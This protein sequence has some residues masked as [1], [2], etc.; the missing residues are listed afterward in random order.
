MALML[1]LPASGCFIF[2][3]SG[4]G[5]EGTGGQAD[6]GDAA[7]GADETG[8]PEPEPEPFEHRIFVAQHLEYDN[9]GPGGET[10]YNIHEACDNTDVADDT[11]A[12]SNAMMMDG[13]QVRYGFDHE[14]EPGAAL[15]A[16]PDSWAE[17]Y[18]IEPFTEGFATPSDEE[19]ADFF[20]L[21]MYSGH[22]GPGEFATNFDAEAPGENTC[23]VEHGW[24]VRLGLYCGQRAKVAAY[25]A[26]CVAG[27]DEGL[28]P[29]PPSA[30]DAGFWQPWDPVCWAPFD[31]TILQSLLNQTL[32]FVD[33]PIVSVDQGEVWYSHTKI[34]QAP[35]VG[36]IGTHAL[37]E[38]SGQ[39]NQPAAITRGSSEHDMSGHLYLS[40]I[41]SGIN[42]E[43]IL[44]EDAVYTGII[45]LSWEG[46]S[47]I[48][49]AEGEE[50][51]YAAQ[52]PETNPVCIP[53]HFDVCDPEVDS[54]NPPGVP[55]LDCPPGA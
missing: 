42:L 1:G 23:Y 5:E 37:D 4:D 32:A 45:W 27:F 46:H 21:A 51:I 24:D 12:M 31:C 39:A 30:E 52:A 11:I 22:G 10:I 33:S 2:E 34:V 38:Q 54:P 40:D 35:A 41:N 17:S 29:R 49:N 15:K 48:F 53:D 44:P 9:L 13:W 26:S 25:S 7:D 36:W 3:S 28:C 6:D 47:A 8:T 19:D 16:R 50:I 55:L 18:P 14:R 43:Q 20:D